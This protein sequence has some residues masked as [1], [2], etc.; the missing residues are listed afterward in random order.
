MRQKHSWA[1]YGVHRFSEKTRIHLKTLGARQVTLS[2]IHSEDPQ[3]FVATVQKFH[4]HGDLVSDFCTPAHDTHAT[5]ALS[6]KA[7]FSVI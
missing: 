4:I 6:V 5:V 2:K 3:I 1:S 7:A